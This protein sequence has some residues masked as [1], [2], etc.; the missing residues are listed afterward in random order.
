M[1]I[2]M[3]MIF[4]VTMQLLVPALS[5]MPRTRITVSIITTRNPTKLKKEP[6]SRSESSKTGLL[7]LAGSRRPNP[8][9]KLSIYAEKPTATAMLLTAYSRIRSQPMIQA[10]SSPSVA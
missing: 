6:V 9:S 5:R 2:R 7:T 8:L 1:K 10:T 3:A 4:T